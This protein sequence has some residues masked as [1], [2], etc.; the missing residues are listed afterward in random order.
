LSGRSRPPRVCS[1]VDFPLPEG[2]VTARNSPSSTE[3]S[4][5]SSAVAVPRR[6]VAPLTCS[7]AGVDSGRA[8]VGPLGGWVR[9]RGGGGTLGGGG[10]P[11]RKEGGGASRTVMIGSFG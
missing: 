7:R 11:A 8:W 1:S 3:R 5:W 2:P 4:T 6:R 9:G 10:A